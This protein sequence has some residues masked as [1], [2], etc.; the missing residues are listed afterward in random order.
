[1]NHCLSRSHNK[2]TRNKKKYF[3]RAVKNEKYLKIPAL[4][5]HVTSISVYQHQC[6]QPERGVDH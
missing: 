1:M 2:D 4:N 3:L 5:G 6:R